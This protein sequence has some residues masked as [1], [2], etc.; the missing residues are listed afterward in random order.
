MPPR[1]EELTISVIG[2]L[3][4]KAKAF[5]SLYGTPSGPR[6]L[7]ISVLDSARQTRHLFT[8]GGGEAAGRNARR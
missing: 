8:I 5:S 4:S 7:F 1:S 6:A 2:S 3:S